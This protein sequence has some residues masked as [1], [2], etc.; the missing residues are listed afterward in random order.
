[1]LLCRRWVEALQDT[2][3]ILDFPIAEQVIEVPKISCSPCPSRSLVPD[4]QSAEQLVEVPTVLSPTRIALQ[5]A[6]QI[7]SIPAPRGRVQGFL[8]QQSSTATTSYLERISERTVEQIVDFP[9]SGGGLGQGSSSSVGPADEDFPVKVF[10]L[11]PGTKKSATSEAVPSPSVPTSVSSWTWAAYEAAEVAKRDAKTPGDASPCC[12]SIGP[13]RQEEEE[14]EEE[15]EEEDFL[16]LLP[17]VP[18][19]A[20]ARRR[21]WQWFVPRWLRWFSSSR[22]AS[23]SFD[24]KLMLSNIMGALDEKDIYAVAPPVVDSGGGMCYAGIA[25]CGCP[26]G[27][28]PSVVVRPKMVYIM[29]SMT[30]RTVFCGHGTLSVDLRQWHV[31]GL[32]FACL[33]TSRYVPLRGW[34]AQTLSILAGMN[35]KDCFAFYTVVHTPVVCND[36]CLGYGVRKLRILR[37]CSPSTRSSTSL[38]CRRGLFP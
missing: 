4:P 32:G 24:G 6:E 1:M 29:A 3:R 35:Q 28:F 2:L 18:P 25:G 7:V 11:F 16:K 38:S 12:R 34:Q 27:M 10:A 13:F 30:R 23:P 37:S 17:H 5:I 15:E 20:R 14:K 36:R 8:P 33:Y 26:R 31:Q 19:V 21:Q 22:A 9:S